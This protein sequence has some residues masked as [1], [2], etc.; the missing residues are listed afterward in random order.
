MVVFGLGK[1]LF[2]KSGESVNLIK[3]SD[4]TPTKAKNGA[5]F[6]VRNSWAVFRRRFLALLV[7]T[8]FKTLFTNKFLAA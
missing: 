1:D 2:F 6:P 8:L 5:E 7:V 4:L 3:K